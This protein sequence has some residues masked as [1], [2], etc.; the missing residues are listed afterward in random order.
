MVRKKK[1]RQSPIQETKN[2]TEVHALSTC[3][4]SIQTVFLR[5]RGND[6]QLVRGDLTGRNSGHDAV[7]TTALDVGEIAVIGILKR[8]QAWVEDML[9]PETGEDARDRGLANLAAALGSGM[10]AVVLE[11]LELLD[12]AD[13]KKLGAAVL[14]VRAQAVGDLL[15]QRF[16]LDLKDFLD[17]REAAAAACACLGEA[18]DLIEVLALLVADDGANIAFG[19]IVTRTDLSVVRQGVGVAICWLLHAEDEFGRGRLKAFGGTDEREELG[20]VVCVADL[21]AADEFLAVLCEDVFF[22]NAAE[23]VAVHERLVLGVICERVTETRDLD[24]E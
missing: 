18:L 13:R 2:L 7:E 11:R 17:L 22:V 1:S 19:D 20:V 21:D 3:D 16:E 6:G 24:T 9:V 23:R 14:E 12:L 15:T 8:G 10:M 4:F 5:D